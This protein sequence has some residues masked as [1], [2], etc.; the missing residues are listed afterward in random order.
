MNCIISETT[1]IEALKRKLGKR[2]IW[3]GLEPQQSEYRQKHMNWVIKKCS[4]PHCCNGLRGKGM[5]L[6]CGGQGA[7]V[8]V[9]AKTAFDG[10]FQPH[11][12]TDPVIRPMDYAIKTVK[13]ILKRR[14]S[15]CLVSV[16][17]TSCWHWPMIFYFQ[18][19]PWA[20]AWITW[21]KNIITGRSEITTQN[22]GFGVDP[23]A[24]KKADHWNH[25]PQPERPGA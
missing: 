3:T 1:D 6:K 18:N 12:P 11:F 9:S 20:G 21:W 10:S 16:S 7:Y 13:Q 5:I 22:H 4:R 8:K 14:K 2:P 15:R 23:E 24:V 17:V 19:A 25:T